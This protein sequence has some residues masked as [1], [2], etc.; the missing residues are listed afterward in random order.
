VKVLGS[1]LLAGVAVAVLPR[2]SSG[3]TQ[4][5]VGTLLA[6]GILVGGVTSAALF[7]G[8]SRDM[9]LPARVG[10]FFVAYNALI[11]LVKFVLAPAGLY[12]VNRERWFQATFGTKG[13]VWLS[14]ALVLVLYVVAFT[15]L[16]L[17]ARRSLGTRVTPS[18]RNRGVPRERSVRKLV[19][20]LIVGVLA[21]VGLSLLALLSV[22]G[23]G[24]AQY[25]EFV[26][27][28]GLAL[29]IAVA[30]GLASVLLVMGFRS[31]EDR[32]RAVA[33]AAA[34]LNLFWLGIAFL[35]LFHVLWVVYVLV[36]TSIWP[37][38]TV[39]PK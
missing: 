10:I 15:V 13:I 17:G 2:V 27:S 39:V 7:L 3:G 24:G 38:K 37:L 29:L 1:F 30:L 16:Y 4:P 19:I 5:P 36:L 18:K 34:L 6:V 21:V 22:F 20:G 28:S 8:I 33:D 32:T 11:V 35:L 9:K 25:L 14:A 26:F 31:V 12:Q 23:G